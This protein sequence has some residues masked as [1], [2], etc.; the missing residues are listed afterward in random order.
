MGSGHLAVFPV[1]LKL[2][3]QTPSMPDD[4]CS[5]APALL[6]GF[7]ER[8]APAQ[9]AELANAQSFLK[10]LCRV[11]DVPEPDP[12]TKDP[13]R[14]GYVFE[15]P[16]V[17]EDQA[18]VASGR[19]DL[20]RRGCFVLETK[21]GVDEQTLQRGKVTP[22]GHGRRGSPAWHRAMAAAKEQAA[23]YAQNLDRGSWKEPLP[24]LLVVCDVGHCIDL[25]ANFGHPQ[26]YVP[27]PDQR[28][29]RI[30]LVDLRKDKVRELLRLA[31]LDP[32]RLDP[33]Q[34][35]AE[36]TRELATTLA[37]LAA[38]LEAAGMAP[39]A[40][41]AFLTRS[42]FTM[43]AED[44]GLLPDRA[45]TR[46]LRSYEDQLELLPAGL[47]AVWAAME[48][49]GYSPDL[50]AHVRKF[51]GSLFAETWAPSL[52]REQLGLLLQAAGSDWTAVEPAIFGTLLERALDPRERHKLGAH[53]TP[54]AF[55][56]R[57]VVPTIID[58]LR[59]E[60]E[61]VQVAIASTE[62]EHE[63]AVYRSDA[64]RT[65]GERR[66]RKAVVEMLGAYRRRL[67]KVVILDP[68]C[69]SGNF[70]YVTLEHMKRIEGEVRE[71]QERYGESALEME[72]VAVMP[73]QFHGLEVNPR[74]AAITDLVL[75][76]GFL[77]WH[78]RSFGGPHA[79]HEPVLRA[80]G[81]I[82]CRDAV[83]RF[84]ARQPR[85]ATNG[86]VLTVWDGRTTRLHPATGAEVPDPD[87]RIPV[88]DYR[89][90]HLTG[91]T[92]TSP[93]QIGRGSI[94]A[95]WVSVRTWRFLGHRPR[96]SRD[97]EVLVAYG[98][99]GNGQLQY[100]VEYHAPT[101]RASA[102]ESE[103]EF[104]EVIGK[105]C[106]IDRSLV[107]TQKPPFGER[108]HPV[109]G[110]QERTRIF[111]AGLSRALAAPLVDIAVPV[112][113][114]VARPT[115]GDDS[116]AGCHVFLHEGVQ[117]VGR[118]ILQGF[119]PAPAK[120]SRH[121]GLHRDP[122]EDLLALMGAAAKQSLFHAPE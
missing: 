102:V 16:V 73:G 10:E 122:G 84:E 107:S 30:H 44:T 55:V 118:R 108:C 62:E 69:G 51:S 89:G 4:S 64:E 92:G 31:W 113:P 82:E 120:A 40:V 99:V 8:W 90:I 57:L 21:Q 76:I 85:T 121:R 110:G 42:L 3:F 91:V 13:E 94:Q 28:T 109:N 117:R 5:Q 119:H 83:L 101:S 63:A 79:I 54:R 41:F 97:Y 36:V 93:G 35:Q 17:F 52:S 116:G 95:G 68:A 6:D 96:F 71:V 59:Q 9:A 56:E 53:F 81:N 39:D 15:R 77:Q 87:A 111:A 78:L 37:R 22:V 103:Y 100:A 14:D 48:S 34:Y 25:Y 75:W 47:T 112:Q 88:Y 27:F 65:A 67:A 115:V 19:I 2:S 29:F 105:V 104:I 45:F 50:R 43:F 24:P 33:S 70:L 38:S 106:R 18:G 26:R 23:R 32:T 46:M 74:A 58:P 12:A 114:E 7:I 49:G 80:Y 98:C 66:T 60:W 20:Y 72:S 86:S 1:G 61:A 11:L